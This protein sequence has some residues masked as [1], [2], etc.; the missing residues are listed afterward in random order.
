MPVVVRVHQGAQVQ[1][2]AL[3]SRFGEQSSYRH[4]N[5]RTP[6]LVLAPTDIRVASPYVSAYMQ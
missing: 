1:R 2:E 5:N 4:R 3:D 6:R